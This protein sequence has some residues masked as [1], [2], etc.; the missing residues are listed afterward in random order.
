MVIDA[1]G[2]AITPGLEDEIDDLAY[3]FEQWFSPDSWSRQNDRGQLV[4]QFLRDDIQAIELA[5]SGM[6]ARRA[7]REA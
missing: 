2:S 7:P 3:W 6:S 1:L 5:L 4:L